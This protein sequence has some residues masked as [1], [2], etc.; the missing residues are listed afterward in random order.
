VNILALTCDEFA[1]AVHARHG[2][3]RFHAE[4]AYREVFQHGRRRVSGAPAFT[5]AP[6]LAAAMDAE[7]QF[8]GLRIAAQQAAGGVLKFATELADGEVIESVVIPDKGRSTLCVSS[9]VGCRM[10]CKFC[11]TG[12]MGLRRNLAAAEIVAQVHLARFTIRRPVDNVVFMGMGEPL[13]NADAVL[14]AI[15]VLADPRGL[16]LAY[17]RITVSTAGH[18]DGLRALAAAALPN[19]R[20]AVSLHAANDA[21]R[22]RLVPLNVR[23]PLALLKEALRAYPLGRGGVFFIEYVLLAGV[24]D[25]PAHAGELARYLEGLPVRVNVIPYNG[26]SARRFVTPDRAQIDQ[27]CAR[28]AA[29]GLFVRRRHPR[30]RDV[31][32]ACGQLGAAVAAA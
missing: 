18:V 29:E 14:Q 10:G 8:P 1:R 30:G 26:G 20:V 3:G 22:S 31:L 4:A 28:L 19:L 6:A 16:N 24:N 12:E 5:A 27:F 2:K 21:L 7:L 25:G 11:V 32:A 17:R 9:Q 23:Y 15:R 13:D